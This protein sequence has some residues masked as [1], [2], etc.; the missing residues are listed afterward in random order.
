MQCVTRTGLGFDSVSPSLS[1]G[2]VT[3]PIHSGLRWSWPQ[4]LV[5]DGLNVDDS[6]L[7]LD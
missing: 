5:L 4:Y 1:P 6:F 7:H 3:D 2:L